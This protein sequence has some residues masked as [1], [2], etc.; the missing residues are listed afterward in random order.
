MK[1]CQ[2]PVDEE[3]TYLRRFCPCQFGFCKIYQC[4]PKKETSWLLAEKVSKRVPTWL[5]LTRLLDGFTGSLVVTSCSSS[6]APVDRRPPTRRCA[7]RPCAGRVPGASVSRGFSCEKTSRHMSYH[8]KKKVT[9]C[10]DYTDVS[11]ICVIDT[12]TTPW[13]S[14]R[15]ASVHLRALALWHATTSRPR[16]SAHPPTRGFRQLVGRGKYESTWNSMLMDDC[17]CC[18]DS[19]AFQH[20]LTTYVDSKH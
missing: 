4:K 17:N 1:T 19:K 11:S 7:V 18:Q 2:R 14:K 3:C 13:R 8:V 15:S 20:V 6:D 10:Q 16:T 12:R 9:K 5:G